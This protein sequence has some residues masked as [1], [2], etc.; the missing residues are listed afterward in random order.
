MDTF[1]MNSL[2]T[3]YQSSLIFK[4][5]LSFVGRKM[6]FHSKK[7]MFFLGEDLIYTGA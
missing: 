2:G 5:V 7:K 6:F 1:R 4:D 3:E